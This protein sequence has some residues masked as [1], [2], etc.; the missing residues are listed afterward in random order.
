M[1]DVMNTQRDESLGDENSS[2]NKTRQ[3]A[4]KVKK[5]KLVRRR[6]KKNKKKTKTKYGFGSQSSR[7][8]SGGIYKTKKCSTPGPKVTNK[9]G[10]T[11][12]YSIG[13]VF[14]FTCFLLPRVKNCVPL[15]HK[16]PGRTQEVD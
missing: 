12:V 4:K 5:T 7:F 1:A 11:V 2:C 8:A 16:Y 15:Y 14:I 3:S 10:Y 13:S 9:R 6:V